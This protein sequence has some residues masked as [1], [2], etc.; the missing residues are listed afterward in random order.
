MNFT[1]INKNTGNVNNT[2]AATI[3]HQE[4]V[5]KRLVEA[6]RTVDVALTS[7]EARAIRSALA[8]AEGE[9]KK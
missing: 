6:L 4:A 5:I 7:E 3:A 2:D 8:F 9:G 1:Q